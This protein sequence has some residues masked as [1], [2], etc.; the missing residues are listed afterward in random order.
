MSVESKGGNLSYQFNLT[1]M[2]TSILY[3]KIPIRNGI[4]INRRRFASVLFLVVSMTLFSFKETI[5]TIVIYPPVCQNLN[6]SFVIEHEMFKLGGVLSVLNADGI[7]TAE[8][9][10]VSSPTEVDVTAWVPGK[11]ILIFKT[12]NYNSIVATI[13]IP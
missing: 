10:V 5:K 13:D 3:A 4:G 8:Q 6:E 12:G 2:N 9:N 1:K 7:I 11:Y